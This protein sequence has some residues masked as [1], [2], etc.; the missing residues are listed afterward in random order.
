MPHLVISAHGGRI[1]GA[2]E[3]S[4]CLTGYS[5]QELESLRL[6][7]LLGR[8]EYPQV[9]AFLEQSLLS[10]GG[11][12]ERVPLHCK[13]GLLR[14]VTFT[15]E[16]PRQSSSSGGPEGMSSEGYHPLPVL[17][18][19]LKDV[20]EQ[21][22]IGQELQQRKQALSSLHTLADVVSQAPELER[23]LEIALGQ[24]LHMLGLEMGGI[25][26]AEQR[27]REGPFALRAVQGVSSELVEAAPLL[28]PDAPLWQQINGSLRAYSAVGG[29]A[30]LL[31]R[32]RASSSPDLL[33][34]VWRE[35]GMHAFM[36]LPLGG[37]QRPCGLLLVGATQP[38]HF[39]ARDR[40]LLELSAHQL[41][42]ALENGLLFRELMERIRD[43]SAMRQFSANILRDMS[44]GLLTV[45]AEGR[46]TTFNP[47]AERILHY[48]AS[49]VRGRTLAALLGEDS[50]MFTLVRE[51]MRSGV[52]HTR[53]E[54]VVQR[55]DGRPVPVGASVA[56]LRVCPD[57][58]S[59]NGN[60]EDQVIGAVV[61]FTDLTEQKRT[62]DQQRH[63]DR[64]ALLGEMTAVLAHE[65]RNPLAGIVHGIQ[66]LVE[67]SSLE[68]EAADYAQLILE[69]SRR[70]SRLLDDI[71]LI[72]RPQEVELVPCDLVTILEGVLRQW[73][74]RAA[75]HGVEV[76]TSY[77]PDTGLPMGD[78][79]RLEHVF[80]NLISNALD[81]M[82]E[83]GV[84]WL[85]VKPTRLASSLLGQ[86]PHPAVRVEVE[87]TGVGIPAHA[88]QRV[89]D[90]FFTTRK[91][92]TG[93][94]LAIT[95][96]IVRDH[97]GKIE[98]QSEEGKGTLFSVTLPL[99]EGEAG[100]ASTGI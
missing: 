18:C 38:R 52:P 47:A 30:S 34:S 36:A 92:G 37:Q 80:T 85:R 81:A 77:A 6:G 53:R 87:D 1:L 100:P 35:V 72:S 89:F 43:L 68:G 67:E 73:R 69:D 74:A 79:G 45:D 56:L 24:V 16:V 44:D 90:P 19:A 50:E 63:R 51:A 93:L 75:A 70:I 88:L 78:P 65:V 61:V 3:A 7:D 99:P 17:Y 42:M 11:E 10:G 33:P 32:E 27:D 25:Y 14:S 5:V 95:R 54:L 13:D 71:L 86:D 96:R 4:A 57:A 66:Y 31:V 39:N 20:T 40:D 46:I 15:V 76:R 22:R 64:L 83:G 9:M 84:L 41:T 94:G 97:R 60:G 55:G 48:S 28:S 62:E 23:V 91:K 2:N 21:E 12:L 29:R 58:S 8:R 59:G 82:P 98:V 26:V 49:Q